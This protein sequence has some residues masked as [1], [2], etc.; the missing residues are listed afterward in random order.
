[1][2]DLLLGFQFLQLAA[3]EVTLPPAFRCHQFSMFSPSNGLE[4]PSGR[5]P[6]IEYAFA[7]EVSAELPPAG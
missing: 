4:Y 3:D 5:A 1:M 2:P 6:A 7:T